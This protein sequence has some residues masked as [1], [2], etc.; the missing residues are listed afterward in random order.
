MPSRRT[1]TVGELTELRRLGDAVRHA[2]RGDRGPAVLLVVQSVCVYRARGS[3]LSELGRALGVE[4]MVLRGLDQHT[5]KSTRSTAAAGLWSPPAIG[6]LPPHGSGVLA[7]TGD[8]RP[9]G[10]DFARGMKII[11]DRV[12]PGSSSPNGA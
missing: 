5:A 1:L 6:H 9:G 7:W 11:R 4:L 10:N 2:G 8:G 12:Q 3:S